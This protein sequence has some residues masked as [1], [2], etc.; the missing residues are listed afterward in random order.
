MEDTRRIKACHG[1]RP[2][3]RRRNA[4]GSR[5][6]LVWL[7]VSAG[8]GSSGSGGTPHGDGGGSGPTLDGSI[9]AVEGGG[10]GVDGSVDPTADSSAAGDAFG[11]SGDGGP[12]ST[13]LSSRVKITEVDV[14][15]AYQYNEVDNNGAALGLT[16]LAISPIPGGGSRL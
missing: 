2:L 8:C 15:I 16:P 11:S 9:V 5:A 12:C 3:I 1:R 7:V 13:A 6:G 10:G 4:F 14:G